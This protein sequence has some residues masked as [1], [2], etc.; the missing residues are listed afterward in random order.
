MGVEKILGNSDDWSQAS[1]MQRLIEAGA[2]ESN[3]VRGMPSHVG[4]DLPMYQIRDGEASGL[5]VINGEHHAVADGE[6]F[7]RKSI[8]TSVL[9]N[10]R[11]RQ[12]AT[13]FP[14]TPT[15]FASP[16]RENALP[17]PEAYPTSIPS[18]AIS[19]NLD[20]PA[21]EGLDTKGELSMNQEFFE[22]FMS[23]K[24]RNGAADMAFSSPPKT[25][26]LM[27]PIKIGKM[28]PATPLSQYGA[29]ESISGPLDGD[30]SLFD[31][32][33]VFDAVA[34]LKDLSNSA[35]NTPSKL[36]H[37]RDGTQSSAPCNRDETKDSEVDEDRA[38][39]RKKPK[40]SFFGQV[41]AKVGERKTG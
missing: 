36:L 38:V 5:S 39:S 21:K 12:S 27:S 14:S 31:A 13:A 24:S 4:D 7:E 25:S 28:M 34:A 9:S 26:M 6:A 32:V 23:E 37:G 11:K 16:S 3:F 41:K 8:L 22:Y 2:A 17:A 30:N 20:T 19:F 29:L 33:A 15:K 35:P 40:T 18:P 10:T 1:G